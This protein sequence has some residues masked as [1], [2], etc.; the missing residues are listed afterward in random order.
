MKKIFLYLCILFVSLSYSQNKITIHP[1]LEHIVVEYMNEALE[2]DLNLQPIIFE[3]LDLISF[4]ET[5]RYPAFGYYEPKTKSVLLAPFTNVDYQV[6]RR[7]LFHE[8]SHIFIDHHT[9]TVCLDIL[10]SSP[11]DSFCTISE[12]DWEQQLN[13]LFLLIEEK[14]EDE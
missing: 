8:L 14:L 9:C 10:S 5:L 7:I 3:K 12:L 6:K 11:V 1:K 13:E 2:R 4:D